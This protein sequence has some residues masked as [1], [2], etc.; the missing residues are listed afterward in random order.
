MQSSSLTNLTFSQ[1]PQA[2]SEQEVKLQPLLTVLN[3]QVGHVSAG[4]STEHTEN[5]NEGSLDSKK[6]ALH[7]HSV[8]DLSQFLFS[9]V[10]NKE[11]STR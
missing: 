5:L 4:H 3:T 6:T 9:A 8:S 10:Q 2:A 1:F 11:L 7:S